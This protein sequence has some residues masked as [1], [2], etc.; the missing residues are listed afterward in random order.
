M[1]VLVFALSPQAASAGD[2][3]LPLVRLSS[4]TGVSPRPWPDT[5]AGIHVFNDQLANG[6]TD[7]QAAFA[8]THYAGSQKLTRSQAER[9]RA[10]NPGFLVLHYRLGEGLGYRSVSG[11]CQPDGDWI[12]VVEGDD[13]VREWPGDTAVSP[14]WFF[15]WDGATRVLDCDWGW[16]LME[17]ND[18]VWRAYWHGEALRQVQANANDG[19]FMDSLSGPNGLGTFRPALPAYDPAFE[20]AWETRIAA[21]L[22]WLQSQPLGAYYLVPNVGMWMTTRDR[23]DY[24]A[25]DGVMVEGFAIEADT[26]P[27]ALEDWRL[28][29]S[30]ILGATARGQAVIGQTYALG[31]QERMFALGSYLL[32]KGSRTYLN[33]ESGLEPEWWP[34]YDVAI[35]RPAES[36][37]TDLES[38]YDDVTGLYRRDFD[39]GFVLVNPTSPWDGSGAARTVDLGGT[40]YLAECSGGGI[41]PDSGVPTGSVTYRAVTRATLPPYSAA[42]LLVAPP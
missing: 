16:Y 17:L 24:N 25:A 20:H 35:G 32:V 5:S 10:V 39:N 3:Y 9:L 40:Y 28:Q 15:P 11:G 27:Y 14:S 31:N 36:A 22:S 23:T 1:A 18:P 34:E 2:L 33:L 29:M 13:W 26:S 4:A 12:A 19:I 8:A 37:G 6:L 38:L 30:R 7:A 41:V 21:W 42:V